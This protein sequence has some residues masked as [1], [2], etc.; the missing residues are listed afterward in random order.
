MHI[1]VLVSLPSLI[2]IRVSQSQEVDLKVK[3]KA[4]T[5]LL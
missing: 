1:L 4:E 5:S 2:E 3:V